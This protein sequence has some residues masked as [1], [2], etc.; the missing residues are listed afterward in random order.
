ME[1]KS[2]KAKYRSNKSYE[3]LMNN[4]NIYN[5]NENL[6]FDN[7]NNDDAPITRGEMKHLLQQTVKFLV[8]NIG[9]VNKNVDGVYKD[10]KNSAETILGHTERSVQDLRY[11]LD[12]IEKI[13]Y[14]IN[15]NK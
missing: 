3:R 12:N 7:N 8:D 10:M 15:R 2:N 13:I 14:N 9:D 1:L 4:K 11:K 5:I 6:L